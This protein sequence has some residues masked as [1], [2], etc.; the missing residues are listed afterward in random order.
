MWFRRA[1][2]SPEQS[3][4]GVHSYLHKVSAQHPRELTAGGIL[5]L[6]AIAIFYLTVVRAPEGFIQGRIVSIEEGSTLTTVSEHFEQ[7]DIV[8][9]AF[10]LRVAVILFGGER[11]VVA[12]DYFFKH[13][14]GIFGVAHIITHGQYGLDPV[15]VTLFEGTSIQ[16][17]GEVLSETLPDFDAERFEQVA[18]DREGY[19][20]PDTYFFLPN[21]SERQVVAVLEDTFEEKI[22]EVEEEIIA[23]EK[24]IEDVIT[25]ASILEGEAYT[26]ESQQIIA[27]I[28]WKRIELGIPLQVDATFKYINGKNSFELTFD[29]L[30]ID[31][32]YNTYEYRGL[33]PGPI[34]NPGLAA[35][36]AAVTPIES[37]YLYFLSDRQGNIY[38]SEDFE[39]HKRKKA[40]YLN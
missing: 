22:L 29:D 38:Y 30:E 17:I 23:F 39:E 26:K 1:P 4:Q 32:P 14:E 8:R 19:L 40:I 10:W 5:I 6:L 36:E 31:S 16:E 13:R 28:L 3:L 20:F 35:I 15:R 11:N 7:E 12:G 2:Q 34:S 25:M 21:V 18:D 27:G 24:P 33:P 9:S 37:E